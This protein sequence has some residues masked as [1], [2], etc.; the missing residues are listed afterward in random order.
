MNS[1]TRRQTRQS[2]ES[3]PSAASTRSARVTR[4]AAHAQQEA[5]NFRQWFHKRLEVL[6]KSN[7]LS[8][9]DYDRII[10]EVADLKAS[11]HSNGETP[12]GVYRVTCW[13]PM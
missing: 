5:E 9:E 12:V 4:S 3:Q 10:L 6:L 8:Q 2:N 11:S 1:R 7:Q 13:C